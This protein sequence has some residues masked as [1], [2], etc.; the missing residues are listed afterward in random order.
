MGREFDA[1][2]HAIGIEAAGVTRSGGVAA[3]RAHSS[4]AGY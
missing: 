2:E 1:A 3:L 4:T